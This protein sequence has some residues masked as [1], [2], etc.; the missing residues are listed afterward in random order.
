MKDGFDV[1]TDI[2]SLINVPA[3]L[4]MIDGKVYPDVRPSN[5]KTTD[6][7]VNSLGVTNRVFQKGTANVNIYV[8]NL[9]FGMPN[10]TKLNA[11]CKA[12]KPLLESQFKL[13]FNTSIEDPGTLLQDADGSWFVS[14]QVNYYSMQDDYQNI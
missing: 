1:V 3:I 12:L 4:S 7:V 8:P 13:T 14:I 10:H 5:S 11:I 6:I 9:D 2:R